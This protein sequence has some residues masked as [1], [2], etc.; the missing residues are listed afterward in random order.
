MKGMKGLCVNVKA[1]LDEM[2]PKVCTIV[3]PFSCSV[4]ATHD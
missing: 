2:P 1:E 4:V 3:F